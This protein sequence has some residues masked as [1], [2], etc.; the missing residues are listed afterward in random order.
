VKR[1]LGLLGWLGVALVVASLGIRLFKPEWQEWSP[2][3]AMAGLVVTA[4]YALSQ[5][6]D[7]GRSFQGRGV[8]YGSISAASVVVFLAILVG[9]NWIANRQNKRWDL[10]AGSQFSMSDQTK[11][12]LT[13]LREPVKVQAFYTPELG[14][15]TLSDV[16]DE[17]RYLTGQ[18]SVEYIDALKNPALAQ[19]EGVTTVP[20]VIMRYRDRTERL[21]RVDE[22]TVTNALKKL[23]EGKA[24]KLYVLQGHG[25]HDPDDTSRLGYSRL[26]GELKND[27]FEVAKLT[28]AQE[29][30]IPDDA[31]IVVIGGPKTDYLGPEV[32][33]LRG[34]LTRGGKI[35]LMLDPS[36][37]LDAKPFD[38]L[39]G[40]AREWGIDVGAN[41]VIDNSGIGQAIGAGPEIPL[42]APSR[43][44]HA[45]TR[46]L[47]LLTGYPLA[48]SVKPAAGGTSGRS[49]QIVVET[50]PRSWAESDLKSVIT[51]RRPEMDA[52]KGD[53]PGPIGIVAAV[54]A[55]ATAAAAA[56]GATAESRMVVVG[57]SD[58]LASNFLDIQGNKDMGLN[59]A[60]WLAQQEDMISI[61]PRDPEDRRVNLTVD[62]GRL[63]FWGTV[64]IIPLLL[65][66]TGLRMWWRRR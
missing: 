42:A 47:Q 18:L 61:R 33:L 21:Q 34:Y 64:A 41:I 57:D 3:L 58:F 4:L 44:G 26:A 46:D 50:T 51:D 12:I 24:K 20:T 28:L 27:N 5:W 56:N 60:N 30:K 49:A 19:Q 54:S 6:R 63:V 29:G 48:R 1:I 7:I 45:I 55:P 9:V 8:R 59:I 62:Q 13:N 39:I 35:W 66:G 52:A 36:S 25:E 31:T 22:P 32:D 10:T 17:Y 53:T 16:F 40:F 43:S 11:Q 14:V 37:K 2:R 38:N 65:L 23:L 15:E